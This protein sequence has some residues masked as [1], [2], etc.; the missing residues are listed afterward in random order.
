ML[1][2]CLIG[3]LQLPD[4]VVRETVNYRIYFFRSPVSQLITR[5]NMN[6]IQTKSC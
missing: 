1:K 2:N 3:F 4:K 5:H 6:L